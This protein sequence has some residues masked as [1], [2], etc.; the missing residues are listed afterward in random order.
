MDWLVAIQKWLYGGMA[1]GMR[2]ATDVTGM[3]A[4]IA[5]AFM[6]GIMHALM[7]GHGKSGLVSYHVGRAGQW[8][9]G[10]MTGTLLAV[11]H[12]G[13]AAVLVLAGVAVISRTV[14]GGGHA[15]AFET[16]SAAMI[17]LI[18]LYLV[19]RL[20]IPSAHKH[21]KDGKALAVAA[22][23]V[24]C[25][26]TTFILT[27]ALVRGE[28]AAGIAAVFGMLL[29]VIVTLASV[30]SGAVFARGGLMSLMGRTERFRGA[31]GWSLELAGAL[32]VLMLGV[33]M[34]ARRT[35]TG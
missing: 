8:S 31:L 2:S 34:L 12:V 17:A 6:F 27:Y 18:G 24:P 30:A 14:A 25:P 10:L 32:G 22:G 15:P 21:P 3:P 9:E 5:L 26:L 11:T 1:E 20:L 23:L 16:A 29:G 33:A 35:V 13:M 28:L 4:L 7:P 19:A